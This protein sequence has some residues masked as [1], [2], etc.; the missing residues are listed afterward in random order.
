MTD[1]VLDGP[2]MIGQLFGEGQR[3]THQTGVRPENPKLFTDLT[4][5]TFLLMLDQ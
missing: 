3:V 2:D 1:E 5:F 4:F